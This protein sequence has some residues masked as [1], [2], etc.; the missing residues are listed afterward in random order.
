LEEAVFSAGARTRILS[1]SEQ[2]KALYIQHYRT[3]PERFSTLPP[4]ISPD[5]LIRGRRESVGGQ[6]RRELGIE[7]D[8]QMVLMVGNNFRLKGVDRAIRAMAAL[9]PGLIAQTVLV[10]VGRGREK[11]YRRIADRLGVSD[12]VRFMGSRRDV[13]RFLAAADIFVHPAH[14]ETAGIV[15]IE[16]MAAG[17]PV[18]VTEVCGHS[19]HIRLADAGKIVPSPYRQEDLNRLLAEM[20]TSPQKDQWRQNACRYI[21][22]TDVFS[23]SETAVDIIE[24]VGSCLS[25]QKPG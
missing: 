13:P 22:A 24:Q 20:L 25:C 21:G 4:G 10:V 17:L 6:L 18:L 7:T 15:L 11:K 23:L 19:S 14:E 2:Q 8:K 16:A 12:G 3:S 5:H 1:I 9:P